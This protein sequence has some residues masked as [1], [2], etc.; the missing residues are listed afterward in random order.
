M[1]FISGVVSLSAEFSEPRHGPLEAEL[2]EGAL[3]LQPLDFEPEHSALERPE[4]DASEKKLVPILRTR[5]TLSEPEPYH[6]NLSRLAALSESQLLDSAPTD[7]F[8]RFTKIATRLL[9]APISLVSLVSHDRQFFK[10]M[11]GL[12]GQL[13]DM[14]GTP[15]SGS[16]CRYVVDLR[17]PLVVNNAREHPLVKNNP[18]IEEFGVVA[19]LGAPVVS[20]NGEILGSFCVIDSVPRVWTQEDI[21][22]IG[23]LAGAV[24]SQVVLDFFSRKS[25]LPTL[26]HG[27]PRGEGFNTAAL[28]DTIARTVFVVGSGTKLPIDFTTSPSLEAQQARAAA[29]RQMLTLSEQ[30]EHMSSLS[31]DSDLFSSGSFSADFGAVQPIARTLGDGLRPGYGFAA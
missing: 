21:E 30:V 23:E 7:G 8:D 3:R 18:S 28:K 19:Y 13:A 29:K 12:S 27:L 6:R 25:E 1:C 10:A 14:R 15:I 24:D 26:A 20:C 17:Q 9:K 2:S 4:A 16:F 5:I 31:L 11:Y 22:M